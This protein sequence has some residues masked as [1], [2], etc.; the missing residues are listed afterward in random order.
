MSEKR[1][2]GGGLTEEGRKKKMVEDTSS[3]A[4]KLQRPVLLL[5]LVLV[6]VAGRR[7]APGLSI[8]D[9]KRDLDTILLRNADHELI[10]DRK[11]GASHGVISAT[12]V[13]PL[14]GTWVVDST[15]PRRR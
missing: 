5:S 1:K 14:V 7:E 15:Q 8:Y 4:Y 6:V 9:R 3:C 13:A 2:S 12:F 10:Q 11:I